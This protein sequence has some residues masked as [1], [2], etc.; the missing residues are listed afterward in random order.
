MSKIL[1][2][3]SAGFL[4]SH[5][6]DR[7]IAEGHTVFGIDDM[8]GGVSE[9]INPHCIHTRIDLR[10]TADAKRVITRI[11]PE[12][13]F[14]CAANAAEN[15]AQFS[16]IDITERNVNVFL[17]TLVPAING[18]S[19]KRFIFT[20]SIAVYGALQ[21]PFKETDKPEPEDIYGI[22]KLACEHTLKVLATV[23]KFEYVIVRPH[24]VYGP[25]Q[26][27]RDPYRNV[28]AI[29]LNKI[30][31]NKPYYIY[32]DGK[33][34]RCFTYIS[35]VIDAMMQILR[36]NVSGMTF[37]LGADA[38]YTVNALSGA[39]QELTGGSVKPIHVAARPQEVR[40]AIADHTLAKERIFY[41][42]TVDLRQGI[43]KTWEWVKAQGPQEPVYTPIEIDS[44]LLPETWRDKKI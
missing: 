23:H 22:S 31:K 13:V 37:N 41:T 18:G 40:E 4:G 35:D 5:L 11:A 14:H 2:T 1:V 6:V 8:S 24:N 19:L 9:N 26:N 38:P 12:I 29:F 16:P 30:L 33:Q 43:Q 15:K 21:T 17:N 42:D 28:V 10:K 20:S 25:R 39:I 32:G 34:K 36:R 44:P 3:G 27:M 7:L